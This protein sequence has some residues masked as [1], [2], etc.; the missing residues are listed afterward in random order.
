MKLDLMYAHDATAARKRRCIAIV[1][2][3]VL[4]TA[5]LIWWTFALSRTERRFLGTWAMP[6]SAWQLVITFHADGT[7]TRRTGPLGYPSN[8]Y[9][10]VDGSELVMVHRVCAWLQSGGRLRY[11]AA[12]VFDPK[13]IESV[14]E[15]LEIMSIEADVIRLR[16][17]KEIEFI[18]T[19]SEGV[20][21]YR[22]PFPQRASRRESPATEWNDLE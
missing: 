18:R 2:L 22:L 3:L 20:V 16:G 13:L 17:S 9:W 5:G 6:G 10:Y 4:V 8:G 14:S 15:N 7:F 1:G 19:D 11:T 21:S 12:K